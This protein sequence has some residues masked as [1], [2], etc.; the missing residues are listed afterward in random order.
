MDYN[1]VSCASYSLKSLLLYLWLFNIDANSINPGTSQLT[2][3]QA[4]VG[5][6]VDTP[7]SISNDKV[8]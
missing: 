5:P 1:Y 2:R 8:P 7:L 3:A 6:S 4:L